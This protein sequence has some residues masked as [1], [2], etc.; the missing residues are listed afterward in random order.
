MT[1]NHFPNSR[2]SCVSA[3]TSPR[4]STRHRDFWHHQYS[5]SSHHVVTDS[6]NTTWLPVS[7]RAL[8]P[9]STHLLQIPNCLSFSTS[10]LRCHFLSSPRAVSTLWAK[11]HGSSSLSPCL[12]LGSFC[13]IQGLRRCC[14]GS[15]S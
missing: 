2:Q 7:P 3:C 14:S 1:D 6:P 15:H 10:S 12:H 9:K 4:I 11:G 5:A 8:H 13:L